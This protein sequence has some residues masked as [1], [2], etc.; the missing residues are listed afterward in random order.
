[1]KCRRVADGRV[2]KTCPVCG[3]QYDC[4]RSHAPNR[5][6]CSRKCE[7]QALSTKIEKECLN[8]HK[9]FKVHN[10]NTRR[11][12][13]YCSIKCRAEHQ[14]GKNSC[15]YVHGHGNKGTPEQRHK[16]YKKCYLKTKRKWLERGRNHKLRR[17][18]V[19]GNHTT[20]EWNE[21]L[22]KHDFKCYYC[23]EKMT[24]EEGPKKVTK[25]HV[26]PLIKGGTDNISNIV[27]ACKSCNSSKGAKI[28]EKL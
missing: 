10:N 11:D 8:C 27:P 3:K 5:V 23:G 12:A 7:G 1:M 18:N 21:L 6:Y 20:K 13:K 25:D 15:R 26:V 24:Q 28:I 17:R 22:K 9:T 19:E 16:W 4:K 14:S 2:I